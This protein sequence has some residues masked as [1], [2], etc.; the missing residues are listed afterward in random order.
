WTVKEAKVIDFQLEGASQQMDDIVVN[1]RMNTDRGFARIKFLLEPTSTPGNYSA[2]KAELLSG[3]TWD[4]PAGFLPVMSNLLHDLSMPAFADQ[5]IAEDYAYKVN[6][7][8]TGNHIEVGQYDIAGTKLE[9]FAHI[10]PTNEFRDGG[11]S[12]TLSVLDQSGAKIGTIT[13][14]LLYA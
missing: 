5:E 2:A 9:K 7:A 13:N 1:V 11:V 14:N 8:I 12:V 4:C 3:G 6:G 10:M